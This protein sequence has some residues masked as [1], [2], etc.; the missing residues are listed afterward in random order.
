MRAIARTTIS[1]M[2]PMPGMALAPDELG[3]VDD[4]EH[5]L[6][7][8]ARVECAA[9]GDVAPEQR[10]DRAGV[11]R[12]DRDDRRRG[13]EDRR[14]LDVPGLPEVG[15]HAGVLERV[16]GLQELRATARRAVEVELRRRGGDAAERLAQ[17]GDVRRLV[18][19]D[20]AGELAD[21]AVEATGVDGLLVE[22]GL[23][24]LERQRILE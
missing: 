11:A 16:R 20:L 1:S 23:E 7:G 4:R 3:L 19:R 22:R 9:G 14:R 2:G 6:H 10:A 21:V 18:A 15:A 17:G 13:E 5:F 8:L 12:L 24:V